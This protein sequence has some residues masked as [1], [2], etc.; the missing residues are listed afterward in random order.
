ME[1]A[2]RVLEVSR[3]GYYGL[4]A[5]KICRRRLQHQEIRRRLIELP[6]KDPAL[7]L[8]NLYRLLKP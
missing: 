3:S 8:D 5:E 2:C 6:E 7:A 4:K 1:Q